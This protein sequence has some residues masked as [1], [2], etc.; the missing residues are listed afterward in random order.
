MISGRLRSRD[1]S[2]K[3][4]GG[5]P[6]GRGE[7]CSRCQAGTCPHLLTAAG[8]LEVPLHFQG[9]LREPSILESAG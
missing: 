9:S 7:L 8:F 3:A 6:G 1:H 5:S 4:A 2:P